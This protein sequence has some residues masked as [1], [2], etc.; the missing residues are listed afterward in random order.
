M[1]TDPMS[2]RNLVVDVTP[3]SYVS[4]LEW[5]SQLQFHTIVQ[6]DKT[7]VYTVK[8]VKAKLVTLAD[9]LPEYFKLIVAPYKPDST[10]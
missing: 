6:I 5:T 4:H 1:E 8:E 10:D 9:S 2:H 3:L 7:P